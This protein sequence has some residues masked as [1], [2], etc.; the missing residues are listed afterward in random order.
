MSHGNRVCFWCDDF[1]N[2][3]VNYRCKWL[4]FTYIWRNT[5]KNDWASALD[6][7]SKFM[8]QTQMQMTPYPAEPHAAQEILE[9]LTHTSACPDHILA[10]AAGSS[11]YLRQLLERHG[12]FVLERYDLGGD[13]LD[14]FEAELEKTPLD[15]IPQRLRILKGQ[16][17]LMLALK[18]LS[19]AWDVMEITKRLTRFATLSVTYA[20]RA[21][22]AP[23]L[24]KGQ[25][26][27]KSIGD[28]PKLAGMFVLAM[29]KMGAGEL[30][31]SSDIDLIVLFDDSQFERDDALEARSAFVK[32]TR[33]IA[34][35][36][37]ESTADGYVFRTDLRLR[38]DPAV[39][40]VCLSAGAALIYYES[41][42]RTWERAAYIKAHTVAGDL[43]AGKAFLKNLSPFVWRRHLD[44]TALKDAQ[45]MRLRIRQDKGFYGPI[46]PQGHHVKLG[47][48]GIR[49][50][51]FFVQTQQLICGGRDREL[52]QRETLGALRSLGQK[53]WVPQELAQSL[54][55][56]YKM[57]RQLEHRI[58]MIHDTQT[59][60]VPKNQEE[61]ERLAGLMGQSPQALGAD[62][63]D[64]CERVH[65]QIEAFFAPDDPSDS[66]V[67]QLSPPDHWAH[68]ASLRTD[69]AQRLLRGIWPQFQEALSHAARPEETLNNLEEFF[70]DL[71]SG[72]Q[73]LSLFA[74]NPVLPELLIDVLS[75]SNELSHYLSRNA[76]VFDAVIAGEFFDPWPAQAELVARLRSAIEEARDYEHVLDILR[77]SMKEWSFRIGTHLLRGII[78]APAA[79]GQYTDLAQAVVVTLWEEVVQEFSRNHGPPPGHGAAV[80]AMG[81][82][83]SK[84][85]H[86]RSDLDLIVI[87]D[88]GA[89]AHS[90]GKRPLDTRIY[91]ARLT[92][93]LITAL[94]AYTARGRLYE[95]DMRLRPSGNSGPVATSLTSFTDYQKSEAWTW[96]HLA[97]TRARVIAGA[98]QVCAKVEEAL[99]AVMG[100]PRDESAALRDMIEMRDKIFQTKSTRGQWDAKFENGALQDLELMAQLGALLSRK[101][102]YHLQEGLAG[103]KDHFDEGEI[104]ALQSAA[105]LW[106]KLHVASNLLAA[107]PPADLGELGGG[108][109]VVVLREMAAK[110]AKE[111]Q[112][113]L[114]QARQTGIGSLEKLRKNVEESA[115]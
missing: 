20:A 28:L 115:P 12:A 89:V 95:V 61:F 19:A 49:E 99:D 33:K 86:S 108:G 73:I 1:K 80:I 68:F 47:R 77:N 38:P 87:Y 21:G 59:H 25:V 3:F 54:E 94:S 30:N 42:G 66:Q 102:C 65:G 10:A 101:R 51:E 16:V 5:E 97:L 72:V 15:Q 31:Y 78:D 60:T 8:T 88:A 39:T 92:K 110:D 112:E 76:Q 23:L 56:D 29:G 69:R 2:Y 79:Q 17:A 32:A 58:Q 70:K 103:L 106:N 4:V 11:P 53:G 104:Q 83:G 43:E 13:W 57:L 26:P 24:S 50:I 71:P 9:N 36:L 14:G 100:L 81:S 111:A 85:V 52:R 48:G 105:Q 41:L 90:E 37:S 84:R 93:A 18:D 55:N 113:M 27:G 107:N 46:I 63:I 109:Q 74:A 7:G 67:N 96:E 6:G 34:A 98:P 75:S 40:P 35:I 62:I 64:R 22:L 82:L 114:D 45:D 44:Y 91:Y